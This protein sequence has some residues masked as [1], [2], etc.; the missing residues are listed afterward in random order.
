M[1]IEEF[2]YHLPRELIAQFPLAE[3][4]RS[5]M[6]V[7]SREKG[8][9]IHSYFYHLPSFLRAG[10]LIVVNDTRVIPA[11]LIGRRRK[12]GSKVE[13]LLL[14]EKERNQWIVLGKP[15][16]RLKPGDEIVFG[17]GELIAKVVASGERGER[18][19][20]FSYSG[21]L[22]S[23]IEK[24]GHTPLPPYIKRDD[25]PEDRE[26]YQTL[27]AS[28]PGAVAAPTA[29]LHFTKGVVNKLIEMGVELASIT[30]HIGPGT[31]RPLT[32]EETKKGEL[33]PEYY[34]ISPETAEKVKRALSQ[35]RRVIAV[36]TSTVRTLE[37]VFKE[38]GE[39]VPSSGWCSLFI[40]PGFRFEVISGLLTN[41]HMPRSSLLLLVAAFAGGEL[42]KKAYE[43]AVANK[44]RFLSYGDC[45]LIL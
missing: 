31:F 11:R 38:R 37:G 45:M 35:G 4:D 2:D 33:P 32:E 16:K 12:T 17:E 18:E 42:T 14:R 6:L 22:Y 3:R 26:R 40:R 30:L 8:E 20:I 10:D 34:R 29:G 43:E 7:L 36:G 5:R 44:Y 27:F 15:G 41:F 9:I 25:L 23:I 1:R 19:V 24:I 39:I 13:L 21:D 28:S